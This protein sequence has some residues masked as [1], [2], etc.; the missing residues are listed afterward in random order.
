MKNIALVIILNVF[1][2]TTYGQDSTE[3]KINAALEKEK[4]WQNWITNLYEIGIEKRSDSFKISADVK[5]IILNSSYR[6][7]FFPVKYTFQ[8]VAEFYRAMEIK[9]AMWYMINIYGSDTSKESKEYI[10]KLILPFEQGLEVDKVLISTFY[11]Y[12]LIDPAVGTFTNGRIHIQRP[13]ILEAKFNAVKEMIGYVVSQRKKPNENASKTIGTIK[14]K[15]L[16]ELGKG[17]VRKI[18]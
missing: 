1:C 15:E 9:K 16:G 2:F 11:T 5:K 3:A 13:D 10:L 17:G 4:Y 14:S 6:K 7:T 18:N 8:A 12:A